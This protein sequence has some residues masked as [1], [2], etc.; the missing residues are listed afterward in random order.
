MSRCVFSLCARARVRTRFAGQ[1][2]FRGG[3]KPMAKKS[4]SK[5]NLQ[6]TETE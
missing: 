6:K 5:P 1:V 3:Q 2:V 4:E